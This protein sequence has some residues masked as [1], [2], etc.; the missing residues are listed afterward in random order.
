MKNLS[1]FMLLP[2]RAQCC[3]WLSLVF[4]AAPPA[5]FAKGKQAAE[6]LPSV[7]DTW[8]LCVT[9][10]DVSALPQS[11]AMLGQ[12]AAQYIVENMKLADTRL[13]ISEEAAYY[14]KMA[15]L[16]TESAAAKKLTGKQTERDKLIFAGENQRS[17]K[18]K[19]KKIDEE[20]AKLRDELA[21]AE[22]VSQPIALSPAVKLTGGNLALNFPIPPKNGL[23]YYCCNDQK[24]DALLYGRVTEYFNRIYIEISLW[25]V[26][27]R[28]TTY[29]DSAIFSQE[30]IKEGVTGLA[31]RLFDHI[32]GLLPAWINV[33][34]EP[35]DAVI[36][37]ENYVVNKNEVLDFTPGTVSVTAFAKDH[38][39]FAT[40][41]DLMEGERANVLITLNPMP[42]N[43]FDVTLKSA[44]GTES[45]TLYDGALYAGRTPVKLR[46]PTGS[47]KNLNVETDD[48]KIA[49]TVFR[50]SDR[51]VIFDPKN[52]PLENRT[53]IARKK[54]Y[55][56]YGRFWLALPLAVLGIGLNNTIVAVYSANP[57]PR[58]FQEQQAVYWASMSFSILM[59][60]FLAE[61]F[62]R[63]GRY[64]WEANKESSPL[65]KKPPPPVEP[66]KTA[67][68]PPLNEN[69]GEGESEKPAAATPP[70]N[71]N[72]AE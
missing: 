33:K 40:T 58:L 46:G 19:L 57:D 53:N 24:A 45:A 43:E 37:V 49:Q 13:W 42:I 63:I 65:I 26:Y 17:Y 66:G 52:P 34:A 59:G 10:F 29:T 41:V 16:K 36:I 23:E 72:A 27:A 38:E 35:K 51:P 20:I 7:N 8:T 62:Y 22:A 50:V 54:F 15:Q 67:A 44:A 70:V 32:S 21:K 1:G 48:G 39:T 14:S 9:Q 6:T 28:G 3:F 47:P 55:S 5:L 18:R 61:S 31:D 64:V 25:S 11:R 68:A 4:L 69:A 60:V 12:L 30:N 2:F 71:G 56:A